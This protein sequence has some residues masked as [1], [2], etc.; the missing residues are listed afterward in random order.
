MWFNYNLT[1]E[2]GKTD[3]KIIIA[4]VMAVWIGV[5]LVKL[6]RAIRLATPE[7]VQSTI[8]FC[9]MGLIALETIHLMF[10][11]GLPGLLLLLLLI[12]ALYLGKFIYS[13]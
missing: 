1:V 10:S 3:A 4:F 13:T 8:K 9:I 6:S 12:P 7:A 5:T 11:I 2:K